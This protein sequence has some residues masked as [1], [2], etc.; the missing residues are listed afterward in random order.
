[1]LSF[2]FGGPLLIAIGIVVAFTTL[3]G[4]FLVY[5]R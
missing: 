4:A 3:T 5:R 2:V 1:V